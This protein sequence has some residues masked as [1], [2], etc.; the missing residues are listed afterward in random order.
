MDRLTALREMG[1]PVWQRR[2]V[3]AAEPGTSPEVR[4]STPVSVP[5][6]DWH[7]LAQQV[8]VCQ[9]CGL[10]SGRTQSVFGV[11]DRAAKVLVVGEGPGAE[12]DRQGEPFVGRA[13]LLLNAMLRAV[14]FAR[15][16]VYIANIV[17][18]RPPGNRDPQANEISACLPYLQQ[19]IAWI[20]PRVILCVG[21]V[22][23]QTLLRDESPVGRLRGKVHRLDPPGLP[24]VVT[25][26][27]AYLL[28]S[29][30][31]KRKSWQDLLL[32]QQVLA[33]ADSA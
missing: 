14:G 3:V 29:P 21:R 16:S 4:V 19:Q 20:S 13:G 32:L 9:K 1:I 26:H 15:E 22:S 25:Y 31:Q 10:A 17:K 2:S 33:E 6:A 8:A 11:G 5:G 7:G 30:D 27:P 28:R 24:L 23:A 18:C 12:E